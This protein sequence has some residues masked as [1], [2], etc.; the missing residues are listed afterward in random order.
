MQW[1]QNHLGVTV[2]KPKV[3]EI[4]LHRKV[5]VDVK[6]QPLHVDPRGL[7]AVPGAVLSLNAIGAR[8]LLKICKWTADN[9]QLTFMFKGVPEAIASKEHVTWFT[10]ELVHKSEV[11]ARNLDFRGELHVL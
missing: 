11:T 7:W 3:E 8:S 6:S 1:T 10:G 4:D 2:H 5:M 9:P